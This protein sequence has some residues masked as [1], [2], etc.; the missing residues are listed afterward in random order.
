MVCDECPYKSECIIYKKYQQADE[1]YSKGD[2][3]RLRAL[4]NEIEL[5]EAYLSEMRRDLLKKI[6]QLKE[7]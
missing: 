4:F 1:L 7:K 2:K 6:L 3:Q 5:H